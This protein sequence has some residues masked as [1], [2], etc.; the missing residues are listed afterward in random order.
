L[1]SAR[2]GACPW[3]SSGCDGSGLTARGGCAGIALIGGCD[4][5]RGGVRGI[6]EKLADGLRDRGGDEGSM[7]IAC[8]W[9]PLLI[10]KA[11]A[12]V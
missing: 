7:V 5:D 1:D 11:S 2:L 9:R 3:A 8:S 10:G 6:S 12:R 4:V